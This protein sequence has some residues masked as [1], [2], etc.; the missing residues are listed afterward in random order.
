MK[1][2]SGPKLIDPDEGEKGGWSRVV[3]QKKVYINLNER[4]PLSDEDLD[5]D[6]DVQPIE[7]DMLIPSQ[8][9]LDAFELLDLNPKKSGTVDSDSSFKTAKTQ[10]EV[11]DCNPAKRAPAQVDES[12]A[13]QANKKV[14]TFDA[15]NANELLLDAKE[16]QI[17]IQQ[18]KHEAAKLKQTELKESS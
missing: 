5:C 14:E 3:E 16:Q 11:F 2:D 1:P 15:N 8:Q 12:L 17:L 7:V 13:F 4:R 10:K 9:F 6:D 18:V